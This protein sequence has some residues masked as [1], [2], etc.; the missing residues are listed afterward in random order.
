VALP[1]GV[2]AGR[3]ARR[4]LL[5][6]GGVL[7]RARGAGLGFRTFSWQVRLALDSDLGFLS[8]RCGLCRLLIPGRL[9]RRLIGSV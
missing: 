4:W 9:Y 5:A 8:C 7:A 6:S 3:C 1:L 2:A